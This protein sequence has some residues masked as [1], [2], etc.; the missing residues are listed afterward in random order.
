[1]KKLLK[2]GSNPLLNSPGLAR[3]MISR[4]FNRDSKLA[5]VV[6]GLILVLMQ[7]AMAQVTVQ[8][9]NDSGV[10]D[11]NVW[12]KVPGYPMAPGLLT[13]TP[14]DLFVDLGSTNP[15]EPTSVQLST[16]PTDG[17]TISSISGNMDTVYTCR[18]DYVNSGGMYF[19]YNEPFT[20][21]NGLTPSPPPD[22]QGNAY[23]YDYAEFTINDTNAANNAIDV[24]YVDKFGIPLQLEWFNGSSSDLV[25]GSYVY[26]STKT[27]VSVF[28]NGGLGQAVFA[29]DSTNITAGWTYSG[30]ASYTNFA[31]ILSPQK[32]SI[33]HSVYPYPT[34]TNY[35]NS[36][37]NNPFWLNGASPQ[38]GYYYVGYQA[39]I[40]ANSGGWLVTLAPTT[41]YPLYEISIL[42]DNALP[43][44]N[45]ISFEIGNSNGSQYV[46]GA[47][48]VPAS[49]R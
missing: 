13:T 11:S 2:I 15:P 17:T 22:S 7:T 12:V 36:L 34:I 30:P 28:Q 33:A 3:Q 29:L 21:T 48:V 44:T 41:N 23:R 40:A 9:V 35:L 46:Y 1:M 45:I 10:P 24:T 47:P 32:V 18:I 4:F 16:L 37:T 31:R 27:L 43:Y 20:F 19:T 8:I 42:A 25:S 6:T 5:A 39:G 26:A 14:S 38:G 49:L